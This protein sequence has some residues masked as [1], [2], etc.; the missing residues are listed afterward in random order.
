[1][2]GNTLYFGD[3]LDV[4]RRYIPDESVDLV[5]LDPPFNSNANYN[6]LFAEQDGSRA[7]SQIKAFHDTWHWDQ[8]AASAYEEFTV[9]APHG[10]SQALQAFRTLLG[11]ND[12]LAYLSMMAP[13][14]VELHRVPRS[15]GSLY[16]HCDTTAGHY[17]KIMLDAIFGSRRFLNE[18]GWKRSSAHSDTK[19]GMKR[20]GKIHDLIFV[21]TKQDDYTWN[22]VYTP[23]TPEYLESEYRH[24]APGGRRYK[25]TDVT[26]AKPGGDTEYDW[27]VKRR[28]GSGRGWEADLDDEHLQPKQGMEY[29]AVRPYNGRFW[30]YSK[31]N[32]I[33]FAKSKHLIHRITGMPRLVQYADE[34]PGVPLQD[35][36]DDIPPELGAKSLV[37]CHSLIFG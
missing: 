14:L 6:V 31:P 3:N 11:C 4:L 24:T 28:A 2:S 37:L 13:R 23:Y 10:A 25:E 29:M 15:T 34:M 26:A 36:W 18:I 30:A 12:M 19:Q 35:L 27:R 1:M 7:A 16:L 17:L 9:S 32:M 5:Y 33:D 21:Y 8:A 22:T 20:C